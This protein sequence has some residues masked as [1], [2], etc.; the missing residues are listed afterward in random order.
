MSH[1]YEKAFNIVA[2]QSSTARTILSNKV[3]LIEILEVEHFI[4]FFSLAIAMFMSVYFKKLTL[5]AS[6]T[7]G[8]IALVVYVGCNY[9]PLIFMAVFF[10]LGTAATSWKIKTKQLLGLAEINKGKRNA[11][12]VFANAGVGLILGAIAIIAP[13]KIS[14][15]NLMIACVFSSA[16]ADTLSSELGNI[17]G[18]AYYNVLTL[19]KDIKGLNGVI[20][21]EGILFGVAGSA[22]IALLYYLQLT[23]NFKDVLIIIIAGTCGNLADSIAGATIERKKLIGNNAVNFINTFTASIIGYIL[24]VLL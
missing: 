9:Y 24:Y 3:I 6:L 8:L 12:Q 19:K 16:T 10:V 5:S 14:I 7:G 15:C 18:S 13:S 17:Y 1:A 4:I 20:S 11:F 21:L 22:I 23:N 2:S